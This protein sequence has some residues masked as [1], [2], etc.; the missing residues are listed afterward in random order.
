D[1]LFIQQV[2]TKR[3]TVVEL[4][5]SAHT[6]SKACATYREW[7]NQKRRH[8]TTSPLYKGPV[9]FR[10][11]LEPFSRILFWVLGIYLLLTNFYPLVVGA[12]LVFRLIVVQVILKLAM[13]RLNERKI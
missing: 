7:V 9:K 5:H 6:R 11:A 3:N 10:L 1:D 12:I 13:N 2:A 8:L 4:R